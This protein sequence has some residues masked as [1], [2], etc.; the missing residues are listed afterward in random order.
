LNGTRRLW[1][2][3]LLAALAPAV[4]ADES[5]SPAEKPAAVSPAATPASKTSAP[6]AGADEEFLEFLGSVDTDDADEDWL[7]FLSRTDISKVAKA[8]QK[9]PVATGAPVGVD[10]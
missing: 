8:K 9:A 3:W 7:A 5:K 6:T 2:L 1:L 10:K 4:H